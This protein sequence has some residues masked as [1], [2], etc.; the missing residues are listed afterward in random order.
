MA[1]C[2]RSNS[3]RRSVAPAARITS[4]HTSAMVPTPPAT[5]AAYRMNEASWPPVMLPSP[6]W[7]APIHNTKMMVPD[8]ALMMRLVSS[9]RTRVR[10]IA[11]TKRVSARAAKHC[12]SRGSCVYDCTVGIAVRISPASAETSFVA[13]IKR[14]RVRALLTSLIISAVSGTIVFV[15]WIGARQVGDGSMTGGQLASFI[16]Y[17]AMVAGGGGTIAE[18]WGDVMR[19]AGATER[20][21]ELLRAQQAITEVSAPRI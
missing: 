21:L 9:A 7:R 15:L 18:V 3:S 12:V 1:G 6:T 2:A 5:I 17:A 19:A 11:A 8:T 20:L 4:P 14:T 13:A 10:L 16:L